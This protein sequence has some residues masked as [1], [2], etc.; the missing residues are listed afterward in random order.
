MENQIGRNKFFFVC[1]SAHRPNIVEPTFK[2]VGTRDITWLVAKGEGDLYRSAGASTVVEG[3]GIVESRNLSLVLAQQASCPLLTMDDE[4]GKVSQPVWS[5]E[6]GKFVS[7]FLSFEEAIDRLFE[8][9]DKYPNSHLAGVAPTDNPFFYQ[10]KRIN[11]KAFIVASFMLIKPSDLL[12]DKK[13]ELKEDY[14]FTIQNVLKFG[15]VTRRDDVLMSFNHKSKSGGV[16]QW[17]TTEVQ[18]TVIKYL[19][20]KWKGRYI[21][22]NARRPGEILLKF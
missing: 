21:H 4:L 11:L 3:G 16:S 2:V 18:N 12:F 14:D 17:R 6:K 19:Y 10:R 7:G 13:A 22:L 20:L 5:N 8:G 1:V 15:C 9:F